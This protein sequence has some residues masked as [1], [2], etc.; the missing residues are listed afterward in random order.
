MW[1]RTGVAMAAP[2]ASRAV[3]VRRY[4]LLRPHAKTT[5][6][7]LI[8]ADRSRFSSMSNLPIGADV[9][10]PVTLAHMR[11]EAVCSLVATDQYE[12]RPRS[13]LRSVAQPLDSHGS[14]LPHLSSSPRQFTGLRGS[15][16][17]VPGGGL[18]IALL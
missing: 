12:S 4:R 5:R 17:A 11:Y 14:V 8:T 13:R 1:R 18:R 10:F 6:L 16:E 3:I 2:A 9:R 15:I 7:F